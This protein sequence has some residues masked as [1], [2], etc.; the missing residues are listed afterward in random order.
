M[1]QSVT[2]HEFRKLSDNDTVCAD[3]GQEQHVH[4]AMNHQPDATS[5]ERSAPDVAAPQPDGRREVPPPEQHPEVH[6]V[7]TGVV[8]EAGTGRAMKYRNPWLVWLVWPLIT[9]GIYHFVWYY[10]IHREMADYQPTRRIP[11]AGPVLVLIFLGWT[12]IAPFISYYNTGN[13]IRQAQRAAGI[14]ETTSPLLG[15]VLMFAF[16]VNA[17]YFQ[18]ELNRVVHRYGVPEGTPVEL[19]D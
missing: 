7:T 15:A 3:C 1:S 14:E 11:V 5:Q 10:K 8:G 9:L 18:M 13:R 19:Y 17:L 6:T 16:G 4:D 12:L 2:P